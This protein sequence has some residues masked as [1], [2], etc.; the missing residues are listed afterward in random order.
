MHIS[1]ETYLTNGNQRHYEDLVRVQAGGFSGYNCSH[2]TLSHT[3]QPKEESKKIE[4][5]DLSIRKISQKHIS[6]DVE[7]TLNTISRSMAE[8]SSD[9]ECH[10]NMQRLAEILVSKLSQ[11]ALGKTKI[12]VVR[13]AREKAVAHTPAEYL[14]SRLWLHHVALRYDNFVFDFF[15][16][17]QK[18]KNSPQE[19][20]D[21]FNSEFYD[22]RKSLLCYIPEK[23]DEHLYR[24][25]SL[26]EHY[27]FPR[28]ECAAINIVEISC[29]D[30]M[31]CVN[32]K[33]V[34]NFDQINE[35]L[36]ACHYA[37]VFDK[38]LFL[39]FY[40]RKFDG[41]IHA[42]DELLIW[43]DFNELL[44]LDFFANRQSNT[45]SLYENRMQEFNWPQLKAVAE[46]WRT[47]RTQISDY[48]K[49]AREASPSVRSAYFCNANPDIS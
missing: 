26:I 19:Y 5:S 48:Y 25:F 46:R 47:G 40:Q 30:Y 21:Y 15:R 36:S 16:R 49:T 13:P 3:L 8:V 29:S 20:P 38:K 12:L 37:E 1:D 39:E 10:V 23:K 32:T 35:S 44:Y 11:E 41:E 24:G 4:Q 7:A 33:G 43:H 9:R 2:Y 14:P 42:E 18:E 17:D 45:E 28:R 22:F 6:P 34:I 31:N 27:A